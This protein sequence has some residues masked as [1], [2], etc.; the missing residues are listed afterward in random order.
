MKSLKRR[1]QKLTSFSGYIPIR[2][3]IAKTY[4]FSFF[5]ALVALVVI[6]KGIVPGA[7]WAEDRDEGL[8]NR[9]EELESTIE[10]QEEELK[11][12]QKELQEMKKDIE[13]QL[14][15]KETEDKQTTKEVIKEI[16]GELRMDY[17]EPTPEEKRLETI[18]DDGF[19][20][21]GK[22]DA[23]K[24]G[25][26]Y[27]FDGRFYLDE[28][29][30]KTN[31]FDNRR[32][33]LDFRGTLE[34]YFGY[35]L[36][37]TLIG[38]PVIQEGWLEYHY[39]PF[40]RLKLGQFKEPFSLESQ[41]SARWID[42]VERSMGVTTL[43]PAEDVGIMLFGSFWDSR[44]VYGLGAFNGQGRDEDAVVDDKDVTGRVVVQ[45]FRQQKDSLFEKLYV[46]GSFGFGNNEIDLGNRD[47]KTAGKTTFYDFVSDA[48]SDGRLIRYDAELEWLKGPFDL[49]TEF[50]GTHFDEVKAGIEKD[51][52]T[53][54]SWYITF[55][56]VLTGE[57]AQRNKPIKP[58]KN[59]DVKEG[60]WGAFQLLGRYERFWVTDRDLIEKG[61]ASG[62]DGANAF[63]LGLT[64]WPNVHLKF[65]LNYV[66]TDFDQTIT[67][68]GKELD[69]ENVILMRAQFN[70]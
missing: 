13:V 2:T 52:L 18:Y 32:A 46:G 30:P 37:L 56:Y 19:Y 35:R 6:F 70:F 20:L 31:T 9:I 55:S 29:S 23:L 49:T 16:I 67:V 38:S 24:I 66:Y 47:F 61:I 26:W 58:F 5:V 22:D 62:S 11:A 51:E 42:F 3:K 40:A 48:E 4:P 14:E 64:W 25:G 60:G 57:D 53:V 44:V 1:R 12:T 28:N 17:R 45:P 54:N 33:R 50:I 7:A 68:S 59:F 10:Y 27:Q 15:E 41:Y 69:Y 21:R 39:F 34:D 36:Y 65:M 43:Q 8:R 63:T